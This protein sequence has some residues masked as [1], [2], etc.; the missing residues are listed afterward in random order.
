MAKLDLRQESDRHAEVLDAITRFL[1]LGS[2]SEWDEDSRLAW[3]EAELVSKR[4]LIP[5]HSVLKANERVAEVLDTFYTLAK[6]PIECMGAYC[7]SMARCAS[8]VLAVRLL[9]VKCGVTKPM[10]VAPLFETREDL[11]AS[12]GYGLDPG[13]LCRRE[14]NP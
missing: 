5:A 11:Q 7:I 9:Q 14:R 13:T 10:R 8:D 1:G 2:Y 4:P 6:L 12:C 3:L